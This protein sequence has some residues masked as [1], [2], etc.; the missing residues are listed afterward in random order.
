[1]ES[2]YNCIRTKAPS[3]KL[4]LDSPPGYCGFQAG[5]HTMITIK[6]TS[7]DNQTSVKR[8]CKIHL[9]L[10]DRV[11]QNKDLPLRHK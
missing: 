3:H 2:S 11:S 5:Q 4:I 9:L 10:K 6:A 7:E 1:M 8:E